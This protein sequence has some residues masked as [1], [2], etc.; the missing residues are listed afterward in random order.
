MHASPVEPFVASDTTVVA[1][2]TSATGG[3]VT[4]TPD[5]YSALSICLTGKNSSGVR[6]AESAHVS[7]VA[8]Q[9][10]A[11][12]V[13]NGII[14]ETKL[15]AGAVQAANR[16]VGAVGPVAL[17]DGAVLEEHLHDAAVTVAKIGED[18]VTTVALAPGAVTAPKVATLAAMWEAIEAVVPRKELAAAVARWSSWRR[19]TPT[20]T[21]RGS[22]C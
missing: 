9:V 4:Y 20:P 6:G 8:R 15:A 21:R 22:G 14:D 18:A 10:V 7:T 12:D 5:N 11:S 17:Q 13:V 16:A 19:W 1:T 2:I 3:T